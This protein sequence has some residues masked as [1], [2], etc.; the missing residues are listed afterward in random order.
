MCKRWEDHSH[1]EAG[2]IGIFRKTNLN[3]KKVFCWI[4]LLWIRHR[5]CVLSCSVISSSL[6]FLWTFGLQPTGFLCPSDFA[7]KTTGVGCHFFFQG[8]FPTREQTHFSGIYDCAISGI[9]GNPYMYLLHILGDSDGKE[10]ACNAGD[11]GSIPGSGR[12]PGEG[13]QRSPWGHRIRRDWATYE[14]AQ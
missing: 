5:V 7:G 10:S 14:A 6:Q 9:Y 11:P 12:C 2:S 3:R 13:N 4:E 1:M 8:F